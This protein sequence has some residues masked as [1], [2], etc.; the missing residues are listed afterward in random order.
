M[1]VNPKGRFTRRNK[2]ISQSELRLKGGPFGTW[3]KSV[4]I[5]GGRSTYW[6]LRTHQ[7]R[8]GVEIMAS[9]LS[10]IREEQMRSPGRARISRIQARSYVSWKDLNRYLDWLETN[11]L[12]NKS[13]LN[14]TERGRR[15]LSVWEDELQG[16]FKD[17]GR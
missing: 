15:L 17:L 14:L 16:L 1:T 5:P 2:I 11:G 13:E 4:D 9:I 7:R 10:A 8:N 6:G 3:R 12:L